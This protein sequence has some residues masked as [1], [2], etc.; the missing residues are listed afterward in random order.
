MANY[1]LNNFVRQLSGG[2]IQ[3]FDKYD[4]TQININV[5]IITQNYVI[6]NYIRLESSD[7][8]THIIDFSD[9]NEANM[10][11]SKLQ[12]E[13]DIA[14]NSGGGGGI[15]N[16]YAQLPLVY[17]NSILSINQATST[18]SGYLSY[19]DYNVL[20]N[21]QP[22]LIGT[23]F[24]VSNGGTISYDTNTYLTTISAS[25]TYLTIASASEYISAT[26]GNVYFIETGEYW[27]DATQS[28]G[29][30][31]NLHP[32]GSANFGNFF[33]DSYGTASSNGNYL[34]VSVNGITAGADGNIN[35][36]GGFGATGPQ[37]VTGADGLVGAT[38]PQGVTGANGLNGATGPAGATG[39]NGLNGATGPQ[40][41]TGSNGLNGATGP[42]GATGS[43]GLNGATGPQGIQGIQG[44]QGPT[45]STGP[46]GIQ[47]PTG[48]TGPTGPQGLQGPTGSTG[49][50]GNSIT[51][52]NPL[53]YSILVS[54]GSY[55]SSTNY[56][57]LIY[58]GTNLILGAGTTDNS[59]GILQTAGNIVPSTNNTYNLGSISYQ[60][61]NIYSNSFIKNGG[62]SS[63]FLK[64]DGS[65]DSNVY[66][67]TLTGGI[68]GTGSNNQL[69]FFNGT[70]SLSSNN[71]LY[72]NNS[73]GNFYVGGGTLS[74][75]FQISQPPTGIGTLSASFATFSITGIN[76]QFTNT[77]KPN[78]LIYV[79]GYTYS[80][81]SIISDTSLRISGTTSATVSN[82]TY[83]I[84]GGN[85]FNVY[86]NGN[87][88]FGSTSSK[89]W[90]DSGNNMLNIYGATSY[91]GS[92]ATVNIQTSGSGAGYPALYVN[93]TNGNSP[94]TNSDVPQR[95]TM[96]LQQG[97]SSMYFWNSNIWNPGTLNL[98][99]FGGN[100]QIGA[101][102][103][104]GSQTGSKLTLYGL[105]QNHTQDALFI[106]NASTTISYATSELF[107]I[108]S[109]GNIFIGGSPS[110]SLFQIVQPSSG[111]GTITATLS[112]NTIIG[113]NTQFTNT[114]KI[115]DYI[116]VGGYTYSISTI[117]SDTIISTSATI[118]ATISN[119]LYTL[120]GGKLFNVYGNGNII[121]GSPSTMWYDAR[122]GAL[123][124]G[125]ITSQSSYLLYVN[126]NV[127][128]NSIGSTSLF[129]NSSGTINT[130]GPWINSANGYYSFYGTGNGGMGT[131]TYN[132]GASIGLFSPDGV[133]FLNAA[134]GAGTSGTS[135]YRLNIPNGININ[136]GFNV[137]NNSS[138][139]DN[140]IYKFT[141]Y[142][143][144]S[145]SYAGLKVSSQTGQ[146]NM[147]ACGIA[148]SVGG[149]TPRYNAYGLYVNNS[150]T[151]I[152]GTAVAYGIYSVSGIN[153]FGGRTLINSSLDDG[154]SVLQING[155]FSINGNIIPS[156]SLSYNLGSATYSWST[157]YNN[158]YISGTL[159][160]TDSNIFASYQSS[161][162]GYNQ[163]I[164]QN[165]STSSLASSDFIVSNNL[166]TSTTY[167]GDF[168]INSSNFTGTGSF[169]LPNATYLNS[170]SG[171]LVLGTTTN[172]AIHFV[173]NNS[174]VDSMNISTSG[175]VLIGSSIN[176]GV[177]KL[178]VNGSVISTQFK[179][180][181]LNTAPISSTASGTL[182]E[183][184]IDGNY[185]YVCTAT[186]TWVRSIL[187][188]F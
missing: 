150:T 28:N 39:S 104:L 185:I 72:Y 141:Y 56:T 69:A 171:D 140:T 34:L 74:T 135:S 160:Y 178:Q 172:N 29:V 57:N 123:N 87:I 63:Q 95:V 82:S 26:G 121:F 18:Q 166:S 116:Y 105:G 47:G 157:I 182:G 136:N 98:Q 109:G 59:A 3:L 77:F 115:G 55:T 9:N 142:E 64:A 79:G 62:S 30:N 180:S 128:T 134:G 181:S 5:F 145:N 51:I 144:L 108:T 8:T 32:D 12:V 27:G 20:N 78:D 177:N 107:R 168:G 66:L 45:G 118:S 13:I 129:V 187:A 80:I 106:G 152:G 97:G 91:G 162:N 17:D 42:A 43:N 125:S 149:N 16:I 165:S 175:N 10:A 167:Y 68:T 164:I 163:L 122:Y 50:Q 58:N 156:N 158:Y 161:V 84:I 76:T 131:L 88:V 173:I 151:T 120:P 4:V 49:P 37:G 67:T 117:T 35:I 169:Y 102:N 65:V 60:W 33:I 61:N 119:S 19:T 75:T 86:G 52:L 53:T 154:I 83:S 96:I 110:S 101:V 138:T 73:F 1:V 36:S 114:F 25:S 143:P 130:N 186:N 148:I 71:N 21:M 11:L 183:I 139:N 137:S 22:A 93:R 38:G 147:Y 184:R 41:A 70:N 176:D 126:G 153:Y 132:G 92:N 24:V 133:V 54:N 100:V 170:T 99:Q 179:L 44:I 81:S 174:A 90:W 127:K 113:T 40:G 146:N 31:W 124:I 48:S 23:G 15:A 7:N 89:M 112:T 111:I 94:A 14:K 46:Q 85:L 188:S 159:G 155:T 2:N 103:A 6:N